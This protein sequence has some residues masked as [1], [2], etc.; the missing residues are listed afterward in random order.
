MSWT[1][2]YIA[3]KYGERFAKVKP[4]T[5]ASTQMN[6]QAHSHELS[7]LPEPRQIDEIIA[8]AQT[9]LAEAKGFAQVITL[10]RVMNTL[11]EA[12]DPFMDEIVKLQNTRLGF[13]TDRE[14][15]YPK[16]IVRDC[17]IDLVIAG[18][19]LTGNEMTIIGGNAYLNKEFFTRKLREFP[20]LSNLEMKLF[21]PRMDKENPGTSLVPAR[22]SWVMNG[23]FEE[24]TF[25]ASDKGDERIPVRVNAGQGPDAIQGKADRKLKYRVYRRLLRQE[26]SFVSPLIASED[27]PDEPAN[28]GASQP[29]EVASNYQQL[30][31]EIEA[32]Q[33]LEHAYAVK[34][35]INQAASKKQISND[36]AQDLQRMATAKRW[37]IDRES[38]KARRTQNAPV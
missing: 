10:A 16:E 1:I 2:V 11:R 9:T 3:G 34:K 18:G 35:R 27:G 36:D 25:F 8:G 22:A 19:Q 7:T 26:N 38:K 24:I 23:R 12:L 31:D 28:R 29:A 14:K 30:M 33:T 20:G 13:Q 32:C 4:F 6:N 15:G 37:D 5:I 17:C 21:V